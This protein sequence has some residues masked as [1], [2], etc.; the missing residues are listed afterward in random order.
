MKQAEINFEE[1]K[2]ETEF[3]NL[4]EILDPYE[5][6]KGDYYIV[7]IT[8]AEYC[9]QV[10]MNTEF[11]A[12]ELVV[13]ERYGNLNDKEKYKFK[14]KKLFLNI[15]LDPKRVWLLKNLF[16]AL[17]ISGAHKLKDLPNLLVGRK[18]KARVIP[19]YNHDFDTYFH[20]INKFN[21]A[22]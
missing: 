1:I 9:K 11:I 6:M 10:N 7:E 16:N 3:I 13:K 18:V 14:D 19:Q 5:Q 12:L 2:S 20:I 17:K 15:S 4:D 22:T 8:K 21:Q